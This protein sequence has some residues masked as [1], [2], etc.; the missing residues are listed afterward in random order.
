MLKSDGRG[1]HIDG[2]QS[3]LFIFGR[4]RKLEGVIMTMDKNRLRPVADFLRAK[5][6]PAHEDFPFVGDASATYRMGESSAT[7]PDSFGGKR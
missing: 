5:Y 2:L 4:D 1:L 7:T 6:T 3:I